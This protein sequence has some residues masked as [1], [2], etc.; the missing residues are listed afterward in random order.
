MSKREPWRLLAVFARRLLRRRTNGRRD[1]GTAAQRH[2]GT[3]A[4]RHSG[5]ALRGQHRADLHEARRGTEL[6]VY[7]HLSLDTT[8]ERVFY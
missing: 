3:A 7:K 6:P 5:T 2:S 4:Q 8:F 1:S